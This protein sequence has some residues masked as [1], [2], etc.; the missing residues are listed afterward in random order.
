M[1]WK[2]KLGSCIQE[3]HRDCDVLTVTKINLVV[4]AAPSA[5]EIMQVPVM[6]VPR[7]YIDDESINIGHTWVQFAFF[8]YD[9]ETY[10]FVDIL[11]IKSD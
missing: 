8:Q 5:V 10:F 3:F 4:L 1:L 6:Q 2:L 11:S 7:V 9:L